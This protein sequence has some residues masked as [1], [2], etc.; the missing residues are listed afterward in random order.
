MA[1]LNFMQ[2]LFNVLR[3]VFLCIVDAAC[4]AIGRLDG[5]L[6]TILTCTLQSPQY[7][8]TVSRFDLVILVRLHAKGLPVSYGFIYLHVIQIHLFH[9]CTIQVQ[10][11]YLPVYHTGT[12]TCVSYRY[13]YLPVYHCWSI[14]YSVFTIINIWFGF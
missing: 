12:S 5:L 9:L 6:A 14:Q 4:S 11:V 2:L 10:Y 7:M 3:D 13:I 1:S 8:S